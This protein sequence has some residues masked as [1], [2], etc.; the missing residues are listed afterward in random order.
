MSRV[1]DSH[2]VA[3]HE[4]PMIVPILSIPGALGLGLGS[5]PIPEGRP[6]QN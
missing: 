2:A 3:A 4:N 5:A 6:E 1:L